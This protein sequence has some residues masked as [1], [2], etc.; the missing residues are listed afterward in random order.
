MIGYLCLSVALAAGLLKGY[1]GKRISFDVRSFA[2]SIFVNLLRCL[3]CSIIGFGIVAVGG[4][5]QRLLLSPAELAVCTF[6][7]VTM[8]AFCVC[9][10]YAYQQEAYMFLSIFTMLGAV[11]TGLLGWAV[12]AEPVQWHRLLAMALLVVAVYVMSLYNTDIKGKLTPVAIVILIVGGL[13]SA[14]TDFSQKIYRNGGGKDSAVFT[15]Y[16]YFIACL[17]LLGIWIALKT[18]RRSAPDAALKD[19]RHMGIYWLLSICLFLN[20]FAKTQAVGMLPASQMYPL[21]Q[22][23]NLICSAVMA[24][25]LMKEKP[26]AKS[27]IGIAIAL[28]AVALMSV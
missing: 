21:L 1:V 27:I 15:F 28:V 12:Y 13:G 26:N 18:T 7:A 25:V 24:A 8:A 9:W 3:F 5:V 17:L 4:D 22:G 14:L 16:T 6:A 2:D 10:L 19:C 20:S 23:G 11:V